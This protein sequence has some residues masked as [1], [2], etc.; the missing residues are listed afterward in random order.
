[1][2]CNVQPYSGNEPFVFAEFYPSDAMRVY[3]II[4]RLGLSG[5]RVWHDLEKNMKKKAERLEQSS[6][7]LFFIS[8]VFMERFEASSILSYVVS[9]S[10]PVLA[11]YL[12]ENTPMTAGTRMQLDLRFVTSFTAWDDNMFDSLLSA[13]VLKSCI[14]TNV[15]NS[16][17]FVK[18]EPAPEEPKK[19]PVKPEPAPEEPKKP[20]VKPEPA[21]EEPKAPPV[22][23]EDP[24]EDQLDPWGE[25]TV[26]IPKKPPVSMKESD[27]L[28][29]S[30]TEQTVLQ[31]KLHKAIVWRQETGELF[32]V[33]KMETMIGRKSEKK[34]ADIMLDGNPEISR[35]HAVIYQYKNSF[36]IRDCGSLAGTFVD[37]VQL[38]KDKA[39]ELKNEAFFSLG[40]EN[41]VFL[42]GCAAKTIIDNGRAAV[43]ASED[44]GEIRLLTE[45][46][47][48]LGRAFPWKNGLLEER[49]VSRKHAFI[50]KNDGKYFIQDN[51]SVN[52]TY[53]NGEEL[54]A[55][56]EQRELCSGDCIRL[57]TFKFLYTEC[58]VK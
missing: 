30:D 9:R 14:E 47:I 16:Q 58:T 4:E 10:I 8:G 57:H 55:T 18:P 34:K 42:S 39:V 49:T 24:L 3:P 38:E 20:P 7:F 26:Y 5:V 54:P 40:E 15:N 22:K 36:L 29:E 13:K 27:G 35:N 6:V 51:G 37:G 48:T 45:D 25:R 2:E 50:T 33:S 56:G 41:F 19:P 21:S 46:S 32:V 43:L 44:T 52:G 23:P 53:V 1:M 17:Q 28:E 11:V 31:P 12:D